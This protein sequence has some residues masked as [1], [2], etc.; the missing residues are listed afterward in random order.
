MKS[1]SNIPGIGSKIKY[2]KNFFF[3]ACQNDLSTIGRKQ[4]S[5][6]IE[7]RLSTFEYPLPDLEDLKKSC[8]DIIKENISEKVEYKTSNSEK[9]ATFMYKINKLYKYRFLLG[10]REI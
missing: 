3:I 4:L 2:N 7:K 5:H 10:Q 1:L 8:Q 9:M 6:I